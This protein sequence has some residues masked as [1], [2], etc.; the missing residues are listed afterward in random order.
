[1]LRFPTPRGRGEPHALAFKT[2]GDR[3]RVFLLER[4]DAAVCHLGVAMVIEITHVGRHALGPVA[5]TTSATFVAHIPHT[6]MALR[7]SS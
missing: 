5:D 7:H 3:A 2:N 6:L 1:M 4:A